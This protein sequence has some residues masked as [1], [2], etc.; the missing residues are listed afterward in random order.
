[1]CMWRPQDKLE[2]PLGML[3]ISES[4]FLIG[5]DLTKQ[6]TLCANSRSAYIHL[7]TLGVDVCAT[8]FT[9]TWPLGSEL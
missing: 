9:F 6:A 2:R 1:M 7:P 8:V 4:G 3:L 5:L